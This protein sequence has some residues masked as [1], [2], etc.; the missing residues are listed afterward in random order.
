[1]LPAVEWSESFSCRVDKL[2]VVLLVAKVIKRND[3]HKKKSQTTV[4]YQLEKEI[5]CGNMRDNQFF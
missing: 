2:L 3:M 5:I 1:M 4:N